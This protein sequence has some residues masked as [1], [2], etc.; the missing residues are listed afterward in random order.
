MNVSF[1]IAEHKSKDVLEYVRTNVLGS[2]PCLSFEGARYFVS[3]VDD[4]SRKV[5]V[6]FMKSKNET[7]NRFQT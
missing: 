3:F 2:A 1:G 4:F 6:Y 7:F 5:W